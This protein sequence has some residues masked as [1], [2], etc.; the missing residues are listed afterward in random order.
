[1][2]KKLY[3]DEEFDVNFEIN[4]FEGLLNKKP[5]FIE[6][7][8]ALGDAYTRV[9][10]YEK[11]LEIDERLVQLKPKDPVVLYNLTCSYS[12]VNEV[13]KAFRMIKKAIKY[14]Y[15]DFEYMKRD[16]DLLNLKRDKRF[17][18]YF[19]RVQKRNIK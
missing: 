18:K 1:M 16:R 6:V 5:D 17:Q 8:A 13:D 14:G 10:D 19:E 3:I 12:L 15:C 4:F 2:G 7:L 9:G 11:G